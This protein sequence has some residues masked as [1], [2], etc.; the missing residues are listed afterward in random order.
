L[1]FWVTKAV[2][3]KPGPIRLNFSGMPLFHFSLAVQPGLLKRADIVRWIEVTP[4]VTTLTFTYQSFTIKAHYITPIHEPGS[5]ILL[6]VDST[7]PVKIVF[8]FL[9]MLQPMWPAGMGG[10]YAYWDEDLKAYIISEPTRSHHGLI[11]SPAAQGMS[12]TPAHMLSDVPSEFQID[13]HDPENFSGKYIPI[14]MAGGK[15]ERDKIIA[16][17]QKLAKDPQAIYQDTY[18]HYRQLRKSTLQIRTPEPEINVAL[19]W[20]KVA[21]DNLVVDNPDLGKGLV[22]GLAASG[23]SGRP[24][25][26]W[27]FGGDTYIN[28]LSMNRYGAFETVR[29]V[30]AFMI[31][32]QR[33]DGK[34][35]HEISQAAGSIDWF[36]KYPY[37][38]IHGDTSPY[39]IVAV[40][41]YIKLSGDVDFAREHWKILKRAYEWSLAT[42]ANDDGLMDNKKA[43]LGA[44]EYGKL[45][46]GITTDI[47]VGAVWVKATQAMHDLAQWIGEE[48]FAKTVLKCQKKAEKAFRDKFWDDTS[49][50]YAYAFNENG[51]HVQEFSP[52]NGVGLMWELGDPERSIKTLEK[53]SSSELTTDWGVR[54]ISNKS[55]Y[56]QPLNYNYGAVWPFLNSWVA[57][58]QFKHHMLL[59]GY[60]TLQSTIGHVFTHQLGT[61]GEV[62]SG[63]LHTWP[64]ESVGHQGFST[65]GTVLPLI[66]GLLGL[67][68]NAV[69]KTVQFAPHF[70]AS[71]ER[72]D[73]NNF[74]VGSASFSF[75][76]HRKKETL[77]IAVT[78]RD[79]QGYSMLLAPAMGI[80][81]EIRKIRADGVDMAFDLQTSPQTIQPHI[82]LPMGKATKTVEIDFKPTL[83]I[84]PP[85]NKTMIGDINSGIKILSFERSE[86]ILML[87][88]EGL[89]GKTYCLDT[90]N[91]EHIQSIKGGTLEGKRLFIT[92]SPGNSYEFVQKEIIITII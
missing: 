74:T 31:P 54:S 70:P 11:G 58:A 24:G 68:G 20:A 37:G 86:N 33:K 79:A 18:E 39:F 65:A 62:F 32:F 80:G 73:V 36:G 52:W 91:E 22:A 14:I 41:D 8:S 90:M 60:T 50:F 25:F 26:G 46:G 71:W 56:F 81:T 76:I 45:T 64:Q 69:Q 34:M 9:P 83:E 30:I 57:T 77:S 72:V 63:S 16:L 84:L 61:V 92:F 1:R 78:S 3:S 53:I 19:E 49:R 10:Q 21:Y 43:G 55:G 48:K 42:D 23:T 38:Y 88:C 6:K 27:F 7:E 5:L 4:E 75:K 29:D 82:M 44:L 15:G 89:A 59:Q 67:E 87:K 85:K 28:S 17:Y 47:Y 13:I 12:Y 2:P 40:H 51:D 35:A 66:S